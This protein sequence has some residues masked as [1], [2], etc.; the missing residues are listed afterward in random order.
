MDKIAIISDVHGNL[1]AL[2]TVLADIKQR[3]IDLIYNLGDLV[4]KGPSSAET[5]DLCRQRCQIVVRGNW[6]YAIV[7]EKD[8]PSAAW[9]RSQLSDSQ[10][11]YLRDLPNSHDICISGKQVRLYHASAKSEHHRVYF[12]SDTAEHRAMF[13]NT[14]F[15]GL[16]TPQP[17][18]VIYGDIHS[19]YMLP[20]RIG[21]A[22]NML[23]N[24]G[25][26]GNPLDFPLATYVVVTGVL[27]SHTAA[28]L[29]IEFVRLT[30]DIEGTLEQAG[31]AG[32]PDLEAYRIELQQAIYRGRQKAQT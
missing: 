3:G 18:I 22:T 10:M 6:D 32:L 9:Y 14:P 21:E 29:S 24:V 31:A 1:S 30:Y 25:S 13:D 20:V 19:A 28:P 15:T 16:G 7:H 12:G 26:V 11:A 4:G 23:L 27:E 5:L 17:E 2:E 8:D